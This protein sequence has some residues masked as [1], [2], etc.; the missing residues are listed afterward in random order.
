M[1]EQDSIKIPVHRAVGLSSTGVFLVT[2]AI[3]LLGYVPTHFFAQNVGQFTSGRG[4]L[5]TFQWFLLLASSINMIGDLR[6]GSAYTFYVARGESPKVGTG[7]YFVLRLVMVSAG[8]A[9]LWATAPVL[10]YS[11]EQYLG[12]FALWMLLPVLWSVSTVYMQFWVAEGHSVRGQVPQLVESIVRTSALTVI[13]VQS[14]QLKQ[15]QFDSIIPDVTYAYVLGAASSA[16]YSFPSVWRQTERFR[17][18]VAGRFFRFAW[19]LMG[20]LILLYLSTTIIQFIVVGQLH[21]AEYNVFLA[22]NGLRILALSIPAAVAVPLFPHLSG[23]H[24]RQDYE[25]IRQRTWAALRYT[26]LVVIP[27]VMAMVVYRVNILSILYSKPYAQGATPLAILA[28]SAVPA[29][30]TQIIG[31][32]LNSV[33]QQRLELYLTSTQVA[34]LIVASLVFLYPVYLFGLDGLVA[35]ALAVLVS[36]LGA[37]A[38]NLYFMETRL[39]VRVQFRPIVTILVASAG[40]FFFV[41]RFNGLLPVN[42]YYQLIAGVLLGALV[43]ALILAVVGELSRADVRQIGSSIGLPRRVSDVLARL[44]WRQETWPVNPLPERGAPGLRPLEGE[45]A[46]LAPLPPK[47]PPKP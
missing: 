20:S 22:A 29:A 42:R 25:L 36:S 15:G 9:V 24:K 45:R 1:E 44:C 2:L 46:D 14:L 39:G 19:P 13:A 3:Q 10:P 32:A 11:T 43:Y 6:I 28:L 30:L 40:G 27:L 41:G 5:G 37:L 47:S 34:A 16:V 17:A 21:P 4:A 18:P 31:T 26:A 35:A 8:G 7:T 23:L 38:V 12:L 33:G